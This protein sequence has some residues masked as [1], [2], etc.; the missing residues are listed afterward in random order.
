MRSVWLILLIGMNLL[1]AGSY[2]IFKVLGTYLSSGSLATLRFGLAAMALVAIWRWLPGKT[3]R[4]ADLWRVGVM[5]VFVFCLAPRLQIEGVHRGQAGDTS[6]L[7]AL[8]PL[9]TSIAAALFLREQVPARRWSG[10]M[11]GMLGVLLI[12]QVWREDAQ[13]LK[14]LWAN[15][16]FISSFFCESAYSVLGKPVLER[17]GTFKVL[18][19]GLIAGTIANT[20]LDLCTRTPTLSALQVLPMKAWLLLI[21]LVV[22]CTLIGY[23]LWYVVIRETEVNLAGMT[24]FV[25][26]VAG[27]FLSVIWVGESLHWGQ[28]WGSLVIMLGLMIAL[29]PDKSR[30]R[31]GAESPTALAVIPAQPADRFD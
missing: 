24:I 7:L 10:C 29:R 23:S 14:G 1:W 11:L 5:G 8:D 13:P 2:S 4:G 31:P 28:L 26:P 19:S 16:L 9:V 20:S 15:L 30:L 3:P 18:G 25:Q 6:L 21:Y 22:V 12:S 27:L 17:A